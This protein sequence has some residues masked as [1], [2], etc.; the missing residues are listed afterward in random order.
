MKFLRAR[1][2]LWQSCK[3]FISLVYLKRCI[4]GWCGRP[5]NVNFVRKLKVNHPLAEQLHH[6]F[7]NP[8]MPYLYRNDDS[9]DI[10]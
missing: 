8:R 6:R 5:L 1:N 2:C 4:N 7:G 10:Y 3:A 9:D